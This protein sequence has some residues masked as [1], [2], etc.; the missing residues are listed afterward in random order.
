MDERLAHVH[1]STRPHLHTS[2]A[3]LSAELCYRHPARLAVEHCEVCRRPVCGACL[4]YAESGERLCP[5]DAA[6]FM[7]AG[8]GVT[9]PERYA[10]GIAPSE[11]S[12][13]RPAAAPLPYTGNSTDVTALLAAVA[14]VAA[15]FACTGFTFLFPIFAFALGLAAW[16]QARDSAEPSRT[17]WLAGFGLASGGVFVLMF[18][19]LVA[20]GAACFL[21]AFVSAAAQPGG[22]F[23][24]PFVTPTP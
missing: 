9:P 23:P 12:A 15:L 3:P 8:R 16:L 14:G 10:E 18:V 24:T 1:T 13:A 20:V 7:Q 21:F 11:V 17:R 19:G 6:A 4:W 22:G 5:D 2:I